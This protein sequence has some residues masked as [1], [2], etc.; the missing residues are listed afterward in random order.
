MKADYLL[1]LDSDMVFPA[2]LL[3]RL[4]SHRVKV[5]GC[6]YVKR[7]T[8]YDTLAL[9]LKG[10]PLNR[11]MDGLARVSRMPTGTMLIDMR[12]FENF[13]PPWFENRYEGSEQFVS[14]DYVFC[15]HMWNRNIKMYCDLDLSKEIGHIG[16]NTFYW[17]GVDTEVSG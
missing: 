7:V 12:V 11:K 13:E 10:L 15:D 16:Q 17:P 9:D 8:P 6:D 1:F 14:G 3:A 5:V 2:I 4:L